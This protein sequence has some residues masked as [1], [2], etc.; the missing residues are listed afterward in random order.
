M[1]HFARVKQTVR[2]PFANED[3]DILVSTT[4]QLEGFSVERYIGV[5]S[6][7][8][9]FDATFTRLEQ[10]FARDRA[11]AVHSMV[12]KARAIG[13][14]AVIGLS[15]NCGSFQRQGTK[16]EVCSISAYGTAV[17]IKSRND[18]CPTCEVA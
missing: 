12:R 3:R 4:P 6:G 15:F 10:N 11:M 17:K 14:N 13:A 9:V 2:H 16:K 5:V 8:V 1:G 18:Q 7:D